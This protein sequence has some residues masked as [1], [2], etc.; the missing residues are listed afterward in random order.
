MCALFVLQNGV[1]DHVQAGF[2]RNYMHWLFFHQWNSL[3]Y[4]IYAVRRLVSSWFLR[5]R[6][7]IA[8]CSVFGERHIHNRAFAIV[9]GNI[10]ETM[11]N[12]SNI[13]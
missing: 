10:H 4:K 13:K 6:L 12:N 11:Y 9:S 1:K 7:A 5:N 3:A 8:T 2:T